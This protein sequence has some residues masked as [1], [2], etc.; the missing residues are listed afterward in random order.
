[1]TVTIYNIFG[2]LGSAPMGDVEK[3]I[4]KACDA[5]GELIEYSIKHN[6]YEICESCGGQCSPGSFECD[7]CHR[8]RVSW[9]YDGER[10]RI[11]RGVV[12]GSWREIIPPHFFSIGNHSV[13]YGIDKR[14]QK[15]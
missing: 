8:A 10:W 12:V 6:E 3:S 14:T 11:R 15:M 5:E 2:S 4:E 9:K 1:M 13:Y 7:K